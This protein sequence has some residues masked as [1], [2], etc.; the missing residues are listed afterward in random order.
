MGEPDLAALRASDPEDLVYAGSFQRP[1]MIRA[2]VSA[3]FSDCPPGWGL[4]NDELRITRQLNVRTG[5]DLL[6][7][8][9]GALASE[10][11]TQLLASVAL[12]PARL[13]FDQNTVQSAPDELPIM[14]LKLRALT[15]ESNAQELLERHGR[16][17]Q[18]IVF[19][20]EKPVMA[21]C[22]W[23]LGV[24]MEEYGVSTAFKMQ[25]RPRTDN[26]PS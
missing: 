10:T 22:D 15:D 3:I 9:N 1:K 18:L 7:G 8:Q 25:L 24:T 2:T 4:V 26:G 20:D 17:R 21:L 12:D 16:Q 11:V 6:T 5:T 13:V 23:M 14:V 19:T